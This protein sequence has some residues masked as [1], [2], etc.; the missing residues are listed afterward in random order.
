MNVARSAVTTALYDILKNAYA[1]AS[2]DIRAKAPGQLNN[3][4]QPSMFLIKPAENINQKQALGL[5]I[6]N[7]TYFCLVFAKSS[8]S[9][10]DATYLEQIFDNMLDSI[11]AALMPVIGDLQTLGGLVTHCYINGTIHID[12]PVINPQGAM[13]I[14]ITVLTGV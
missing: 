3:F 1:W 12:S 8:D 11:E 4:D 6:Y 9:V 14:P 2:T 7:L 5:P 10:P 13:W